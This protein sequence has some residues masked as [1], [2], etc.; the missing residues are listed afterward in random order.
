MID[1]VKIGIRNSNAR[2]AAGMT[3]EELAELTDIAQ[4]TLSRYESG[5][6]SVKLDTLTE[7]ATKTGV[8]EG[9]LLGYEEMPMGWVMFL[10][11]TERRVVA[12]AMKIP[13]KAATPEQLIL[14]RIP[15]IIQNATKTV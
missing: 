9:Y 1:P 13:A 4:N 7:I 12:E 14:R 10:S 15:S 2:K 8:S 6:A 5:E 11:A 3:Q